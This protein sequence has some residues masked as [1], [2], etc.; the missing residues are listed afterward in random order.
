MNLTESRIARRLLRTGAALLLSACAISAGVTPAQSVYAQGAPRD[1]ATVKAIEIRYAGPVT[2]S[3]ERILANMRTTIGQPF[4]QTG[5]EEDI[6]N[7]YQTGDVSNVRIFGE[8]TSG[9]VKVI[10]IVQGRFVIKEIVIEGAQSVKVRSLAKQLKA[11]EGAA[12]NED[13][14]EVDRQSLIEVYQN[15]GF[16]NIDVQYKVSRDE[17]AGTAIVYF[18]INEGGKSVLNAIRIE[19]N[20]N[21][22][23]RAI[24]KAMKNTKPKTIFSFITKDGRLEQAKLREDLDAVRELYQNKG[25]IDM[26]VVQTR[27]DRDANGRVTLVIVIKE[28]PQYKIAKLGMS[29]NKMLSEQDFRR[30]LKMKE[31]K[32]YTPKGLKDDMKVFTDFYG[33]RGYVDVQVRPDA[34]PAGIGQVDL[35]YRIEEGIQSYVERVNIEGNSVTKDKV[36]RRELLLAPG[37]I[38]STVFADASKRRLENLNYFEKVE[39]N[40]TDTLVPGRKDM[41]VVLQEKR[42]GEL[43]FGL[44]FSSVDKLVGQATLSQGNFDILNWPTF[45]GGGQKF[46][47]NVAYG[48]TRKDFTMQFTEPYF[49]DTRFAVSTELFYHDTNYTNN[50]F[51]QRSYGAALGVRRPIWRALSGRFE[52]RFEDIRISNVSQFA[53]PL[54]SE[55]G[56]RTRSA[57]TLGLNWD[58]RDNVFLT[59]RGTRIDLSGFIAGGPVLGGGTKIYGWNFEFSHYI[60]LPYDF[61]FLIN[62]QIAGVAP[63][64]GGEFTSVTYQNTTRRVPVYDRLFLGGA[65]NLRGFDYR[66]VGPRDQFNQPLGGRSLGRITTEVTFPIVERVRGAFFY[67]GGVDHRKSF[68]Y[69]MSRYASDAGIG[70]RLDLPVGPIRLDYGIPITREDSSQKKSGKFN[71][72]VGYQF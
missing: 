70:V 44:G 20:Q 24:R 8:P 38:Y 50:D 27:S 64:A 21:I 71:F 57:V 36:V 65:N 14:L 43:S 62:G 46:R 29:G 45:T 11:K 25:Y 1:G 72:N 39:V 67:D 10:V 9:G 69:G 13:Q 63:L 16:N 60:L 30:F 58:T 35:T 40:P 54:T 12:L 41:S 32:L 55:I 51:Q 22:K 19:G 59:R 2:V 5:L 37:D 53:S 68:S 4:N 66:E 17:Q 42:T 23:A 26:E 28:G 33:A 52:Y 6:R 31:G 3:R 61:I 18:A 48:Q 56:S 7:L 47:L 15:K 34:T 49:L